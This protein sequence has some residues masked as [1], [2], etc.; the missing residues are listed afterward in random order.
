MVGYYE[1]ILQEIVGK[2]TG[3]DDSEGEDT[4]GGMQCHPSVFSSHLKICT[5]RQY[6]NNRC[7]WEIDAHKLQQASTS[8]RKVTG[9]VKTGDS[10]AKLEL[11][12]IAHK[13]WFLLLSH[14][15]I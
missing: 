1:L 14:D 9:Q 8:L 6:G 15:L 3:M 5:S 10:A 11:A 13:H 12:W 4:S 2:C 7:Q